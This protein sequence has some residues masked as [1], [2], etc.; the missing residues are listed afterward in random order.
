MEERTGFDGLECAIRV[1]ERHFVQVE[2]VGEGFFL[3]DL[4]LLRDRYLFEHFAS[5]ES[6]LLQFMDMRHEVDPAH[7]RTVGEGVFADTIGG[8][9][10]VDFLQFNTILE[11][12]V[13]DR[14]EPFGEDDTV[15]MGATDT[16]L[17][18]D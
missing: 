3:D 5:H 16:K 6:S 7:L 9:G 17:F 2:T 10:D 8:L 4:Q 11:R 13:A 12:F 15:E 18:A 14:I 1:A